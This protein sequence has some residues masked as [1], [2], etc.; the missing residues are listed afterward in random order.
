MNP[1]LNQ[2]LEKLNRE[3]QLDKERRQKRNEEK[4]LLQQE[5]KKQEAAAKKLE[6]E[7][8]QKLAQLAKSVAA[9]QRTKPKPKQKRLSVPKKGDSKT[10]EQEKQKKQGETEPYS[11]PPYRK[12]VYENEA[13]KLTSETTE[14]SDEDNSNLVISEQIEEEIHIQV[15]DNERFSTDSFPP[16]NVVTKQELLT[17]IKE[18]EA[19]RDKLEDVNQ[20]QHEHIT[21]LLQNSQ[22]NEG[23]V[24]DTTKETF[25]LLKRLNLGDT[26]IMK[27]G[28]KFCTFF[29]RE[30]GCKETEP[31]NDK[32]GFYCERHVDN[33]GVLVKAYHVC[34]FCRVQTGQ[35]LYHP[36][37][38]CLL[39]EKYKYLYRNDSQEQNDD[40]D[41]DSMASSASSLEKKRK[42]D[43]L[44]EK[45][46]KKQKVV[47]KEPM[48]FAKW[49][50]KVKRKK[51][52][53]PILKEESSSSDES[54][55]PP[56]KKK[57]KED[58]ESIKESNL[59]KVLGKMMN[60]ISN[61][62]TKV[63]T[64]ANSRRGRNPVKNRGGGNPR[65]RSRSRSRGR[66]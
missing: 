22:K 34:S 58:K 8:K 63:N 36:A 45:Q 64:N 25:R 44:E 26:I 66:F 51:I 28:K 37:F 15:E 33:S 52:P 32:N 55:S 5:K 54:H 19:S 13:T 12:V 61:L 27:K 14:Q 40:D 38:V 23:L 31:D 53:P 3:E 43:K 39:A 57:K 29:N 41:Q 35:W 6:K 7:Q 46:S 21:E 17:Q 16:N 62:E 60:K 56:P 50:E 24:D 1:S 30:E 59:E 65:H 11:P 4:K 48:N 49:S 47:I 10:K 9:K 2:R 20:K 18:L 42:A